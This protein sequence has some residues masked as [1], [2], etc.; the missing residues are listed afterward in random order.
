M[1]AAISCKKIKIEEIKMKIRSNVKSGGLGLNHNERLV[2]AKSNGL[3]VKTGVKA[4]G[5]GVNH[6]ERLVSAKSNGLTVKTG[7][8]A[9]GIII[10]Q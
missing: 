6:N 2:S 3:T 8:K 1:K 4:G 9:G 7:V 10:N 5:I